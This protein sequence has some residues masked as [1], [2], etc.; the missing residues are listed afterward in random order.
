MRIHMRPIIGTYFTLA[1]VDK[2][3]TGT[4]V[5][6]FRPERKC[7]YDESM[8][9][10]I[11]KDHLSRSKLQEI[12]NERFG[13]L[14]KAAVDVEQGILAVGAELH[15]DAETELIEKEGSKREHIWGINLYPAEKGDAFLEFDSMINLKPAFGNRTRGVDDETVRARIREIMGR[16]VT[17]D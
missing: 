7:Y 12:A 4:S 11:I 1:L 16:I 10:R 6:N 8:G 17:E 5:H 2:E 3:T 13:D 9:I 15:A 14:A